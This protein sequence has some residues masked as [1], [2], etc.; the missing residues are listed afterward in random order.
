MQT[1]RKAIDAMLLVS[2]TWIT[3]ERR[4]ALSE[5]TT[6]RERAFRYY[7]GSFTRGVVSVYVECLRECLS[8]WGDEGHEV[9]HRR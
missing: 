7:I 9:I 8:E 1:A 6:R 5:D 2:P 4:G 3:H